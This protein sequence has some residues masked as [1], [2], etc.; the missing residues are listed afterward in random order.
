[1]KKKKQGTGYAFMPQITLSQNTL[2]H[3]PPSTQRSQE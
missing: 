1:M 3:S 2:T